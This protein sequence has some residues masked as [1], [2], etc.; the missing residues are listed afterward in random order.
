LH[1]QLLITALSP[2]QNTE[3]QSSNDVEN[4][5]GGCPSPGGTVDTDDNGDIL[6]F[7]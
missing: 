3:E 2:P 5:V 7:Y 4:T 6:L 1:L